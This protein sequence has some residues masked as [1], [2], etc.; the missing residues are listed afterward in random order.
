MFDYADWRALVRYIEV[1]R[2]MGVQRFDV[3]VHTV[4]TWRIGIGTFGWS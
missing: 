4:Y 2:G 1:W 3:Y